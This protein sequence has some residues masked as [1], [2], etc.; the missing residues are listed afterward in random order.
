MFPLSPEVIEQG[1]QTI[2]KGVLPAFGIAAGVLALVLAILGKRAGFAGAALALGAGWV[3]ANYLHPVAPWLPGDKRIE[4]LIPAALA[5]TIA[6]LLTRIPRLPAGVGWAA[7][8]A[9]LTL[10]TIRVVPKDAL[11][12]PWWAVPAFALLTTAVGFGLADLSRRLPGAAVPACLGIGL[13][14]VGTV[15]VHAPYASAAEIATLAGAAMFGIAVVALVGKV[16]AGGAMPGAAVV[17]TGVAVL[18]YDYRNTDGNVV[19]WWSFALAT[20]APLAAA[21]FLIPPLRQTGRVWVRLIPV[22]LAAILAVTAVGIA[23][24]YAPYEVAKDKW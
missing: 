6:G 22:V 24:T 16:D 17:L 19:P 12:E 13:F 9:V 5:A 14:A 21:A 23:A 1:Q 10:L 2:I 18:A 7:W 3:A 11:T 15:A 8:A 20:A 4:W